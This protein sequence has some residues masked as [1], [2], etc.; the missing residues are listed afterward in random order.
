MLGRL[1]YVDCVVKEVLRLLPPV[2]GGYRTALRTFELDV[3]APHCGPLDACSRAG[4]G[5]GQ[6]ELVQRSF[7]C[8][9]LNFLTFKMGLGPILFPGFFLPQR[10]VDTCKASCLKSW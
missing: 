6:E 10:P 5:R 4:M 8:Q 1:R 2:S 7:P 9:G 3:S